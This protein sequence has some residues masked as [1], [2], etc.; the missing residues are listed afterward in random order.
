MFYL[1]QVDTRPSGYY[2]VPVDKNTYSFQPMASVNRHIEANNRHPSTQIILPPNFGSNQN[3]KQ[4]Q[5]TVTGTGELKMPPDQV[6]LVVIISSA[7]Q[8]V[9]EAKASVHRRFEY[10]YQTMRKHRVNV[11]FIYRVI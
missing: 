11:S 9:A 3:I 2:A 6:K 5:I 7:K 4:R 1:S 10:V 8:S